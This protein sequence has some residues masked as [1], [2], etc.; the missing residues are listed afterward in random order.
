MTHSDLERR[1]TA[2]ET[3]APDEVLE[4]WDDVRHGPRKQFPHNRHI[5]GGFLTVPE[6]R[7]TIITKFVLDFRFN[8]PIKKFNDWQYPDTNDFRRAKLGGLLARYYND[9]TY[10]AFVTVGFTDPKNPNYDY[11][12]DKAPWT[13]LSM[14]PQEYWQNI[15]NRVAATTWLVN[16]F[17]KIGKSAS[18]LNRQDFIIN[19]LHGVLVYTG[20]SHT[21]AL[22]EADLLT[23]KTKSE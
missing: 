2:G 7:Y 22:R 1:I 16:M 6:H 20:E 21:A 10:Y 17:A 11:L 15:N 13:I 4:V 23:S 9:S 5:G 3:L 8:R 18:E 14:L 19:C 12:L